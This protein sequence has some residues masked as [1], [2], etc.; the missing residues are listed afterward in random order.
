MKIRRLPGVFNCSSFISIKML[1]ILIDPEHLSESQTKNLRIKR[2][3]TGMAVMLSQM[4]VQSAQ[5]KAAIDTAQQMVMRNMIIQ[6][7]LNE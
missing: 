2:R 4:L 6:I 7:E 5:V 3:A 1:R